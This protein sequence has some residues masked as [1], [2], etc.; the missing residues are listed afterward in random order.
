MRQNGG[1]DKYDNLVLVY[2]PI[3][4]LI[5]AKNRETINKYMTILNLNTKQLKKLNELRTKIGLHEI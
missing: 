2:E 1:N 4:K 5:H 3:H